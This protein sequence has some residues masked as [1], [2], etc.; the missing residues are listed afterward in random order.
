M[1]SLTYDKEDKNIY[2][3]ERTIPSINSVGKTGQL[4]VRELNSTTVLHYTQKL[5]QIIFKIEHK[6]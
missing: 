4:H 3:E 1:W 5:T 6:T 2:N